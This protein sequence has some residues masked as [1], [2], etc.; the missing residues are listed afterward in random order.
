MKCLPWICSLL[1]PV[2]FCPSL[3]L[4]SYTWFRIMKI[5]PAHFQTISNNQIST[6]QSNFLGF[7][8]VPKRGH[9]L[10]L[11]LLNADAR[12]IPFLRAFLLG[13]NLE[14]FLFFIF[15]FACIFGF[16]YTFSYFLLLS[17]GIFPPL[18]S[19]SSSFSSVTPMN[20]SIFSSVVT[21]LHC[22]GIYDI[23]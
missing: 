2:T 19:K 1:V 4:E 7:N 14:F 3:T 16:F 15:H 21:A 13:S 9:H 6:W 17:K 23:F 8:C 10:N 5:S 12:E 22:I 18:V 11:T 20:E